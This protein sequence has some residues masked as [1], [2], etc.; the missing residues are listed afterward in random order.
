[1]ELLFVPSLLTIM[2][3]LG[4]DF[5]HDDVQQQ[6]RSINRKAAAIHS[7]MYKR[8]AIPGPGNEEDAS[9]GIPKICG[10]DSHAREYRASSV[11]ARS[12]GGGNRDGGSSSEPLQGHQQHLLS[13]TSV[14][15][16]QGKKEAEE[17]VTQIVH[18]LLNTGKDFVTDVERYLSQWDEAELRKKEL[19]HKLWTGRVWT[20][21]QKRVNEQMCNR[22][23]EAWMRQSLYSRYLHQCNSKGFVFLETYD[24]KEYD[25]FL[26]NIRKP[27]RRQINTSEGAEP[28]F[29]QQQG[30]VKEKR[31]ALCQTDRANAPLQASASRKARA[32]GGTELREPGRIDTIPYH[33]TGSTVVDGCCHQ[34]SC[35]SSRT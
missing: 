26:L 7:Q 25:P 5:A 1:M 6:Q 3:E 17:E 2:G 11:K 23:A 28:V 10:L 18:P 24:P 4:L 22:S 33:I 16:P 13:W 21:V 34:I 29:C 9:C 14:R 35:W 27:N 12:T 8:S 31:A 32:G 19:L 15:Q 20:A 30:G